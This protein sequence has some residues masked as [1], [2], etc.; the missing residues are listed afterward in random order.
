VHR[1][2]PSGL[3]PAPVTLPG[4]QHFQGT[5]NMTTQVE[6]DAARFRPGDRVAIRPVREWLWQVQY[7]ES[8]EGARGTVVDL[9][10]RGHARVAVQFDEADYVKHGLAEGIPDYLWEADSLRTAA[11]RPRQIQ[12]LPESTTQLEVT[13]VLRELLGDHVTML[14]PPLCTIQQDIRHHKPLSDADRQALAA[15][16][17]RVLDDISLSAGCRRLTLQ[18]GDAPTTTT[19]KT[20][21]W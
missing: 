16:G 18:T 19:P 4:E 3:D 14:R 11:L 12:H 15:R 5:P 13:A 2:R 9:R 7:P 1:E 17:V 8:I 6:K 10:V 20:T 21:S